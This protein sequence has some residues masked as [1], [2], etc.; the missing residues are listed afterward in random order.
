V[1]AFWILACLGAPV[2]WSDGQTCI[3]LL[4]AGEKAQ[5][6]KHFD[7]AEKLF[8]EALQEANQMGSDSP[9]LTPALRH[10]A[11]LYMQE[12]KCYRA[13]PFYRRELETYSKLGGNFPQQ[14]HDLLM[15]GHISMLRNDFTDSA[16]QGKR[17]LAVMH[18]AGADSY[19][20]RKEALTLIIYS[21]VQRNIYTATAYKELV[22][23]EEER[24]VKDPTGLAQALNTMAGALAALTD[25][26]ARALSIAYYQRALRILENCGLKND[27]QTASV[28]GGIANFYNSEGKYDEAVQ[29]WRRQLAIY[30]RTK[31]VESPMTA[32]SMRNL[33]YSLHILGSENEA[34]SLNKRALAII[35]KKLGPTCPEA[36][37]VLGYLSTDYFTLGQYDEAKR[38]G[39]QAIAIWRKM[40]IHAEGAS[41][42]DPIV[43]KKLNEFGLGTVTGDAKLLRDKILAQSNAVPE[44]QIHLADL[45]CWLADLYC[46]TGRY[47]DAAP[48]YQESISIY[49]TVGGANHKAD[50]DSAI[51]K[52]RRI[53]SRSDSALKRVNP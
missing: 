38:I 4:L 10:L 31:G 27:N 40:L 35:K 46:L 17:A 25:P 42:I 52:D 12:K 7:Q 2:A 14:I 8:K 28:L 51:A 1:S 44:R 18:N 11:D 45:S 29:N 47:S 9:L 53:S 24:Y 49:R 36:A 39:A 20:D 32:D 33:A 41:T 21:D 50:L 15:L 30:E 34:L 13:E 22:A 26:D 16:E 48:L 43:V 6:D 23:L 37:R 3:K 5:Q 19:V